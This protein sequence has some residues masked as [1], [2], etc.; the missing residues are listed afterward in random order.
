MSD[1]ALSQEL[2]RHFLGAGRVFK[3]KIPNKGAYQRRGRAAICFWAERGRTSND[4]QDDS[5]RVLRV[6]RSAFSRAA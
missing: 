1:L 3:L 4:N 2:V 6:D 5:R